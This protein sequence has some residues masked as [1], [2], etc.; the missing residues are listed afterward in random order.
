[1][2][3]FDRVFNAQPELPVRN[4]ENFPH[5]KA[6]TTATTIAFVHTQNALL[7]NIQWEASHEPRH[8]QQFR[9][10][11]LMVEISASIIWNGQ[12]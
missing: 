6:T 3:V 11:V 1:M 4:M 10:V 8:A 2:T 7:G 12:N 9:L 5:G